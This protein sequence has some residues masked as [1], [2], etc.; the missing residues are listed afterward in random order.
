M[1]AHIEAD[2][3]RLETG[4]G[5]VRALATVFLLMD[6]DDDVAG[7]TPGERATLA[8]LQ[9]LHRVYNDTCCD[10]LES[11]GV[12]ELLDA[13]AVSNVAHPLLSGTVGGGWGGENCPSIGG[14]HSGSAS[15]S[16]S[17]STSPSASVTGGVRAGSSHSA[18]QLQ[19]DPTA[20]SPTLPLVR[21]VES[22]RL[23]HP[24]LND[25]VDDTHARV[26]RLYRELVQEFHSDDLR[27][28]LESL[29]LFEVVPPHCAFGM[30]GG[31]QL[32]PTSS[33][34]A[35]SLTSS[36]TMANAP[37]MDT[38]SSS[39][40][41][42][43]DLFEDQAVAL[44]T[45]LE[46]LEK[47]IVDVSSALQSIDGEERS[48]ILFPWSR[49]LQTP[50]EMYLPIQ[51]ALMMHAVASF[52]RV[53]Q[54]SQLSFKILKILTG[55]EAHTEI[56]REAS[57][58]PA[59]DKSS[60]PSKHASG[61]VPPQAQQLFG[62]HSWILCLNENLKFLKRPTTCEA[63]PRL[64]T[65]LGTLLSNLTTDGASAAA[66]QLPVLRWV[67]TQSGL[68][69][70]MRWVRDMWCSCSDHLVYLQRLLIAQ[71]ETFTFVIV[72]GEDGSHGPVRQV[73]T[74]P[75]TRVDRLVSQ[76]RSILAWGALCFRKS[77]VSWGDL[78]EAP[79]HR[80]AQQLKKLDLPNRNTLSVL[81]LIYSQ[82]ELGTQ[83]AETVD[84]DCFDG[85][86]LQS[87]TPMQAS[88]R[89]FLNE[90]MTAFEFEQRNV[91]FASLTV[92]RGN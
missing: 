22:W 37:R 69:Q 61:P 86:I 63:I 56:G 89:T 70:S 39:A 55:E 59:V 48:M 14:G 34:S 60:S 80:I 46:A 79:L 74:T 4:D 88:L 12:Y 8:G 28:R 44:L 25:S 81:H 77:F 72:E 87:A 1:L 7:T 57:A 76:R 58:M 62:A 3:R 35:S 68:M 13:L 75:T 9:L 92:R 82:L 32:A 52:Q 33:S 85:D 11:R 54:A 27:C 43:N 23:F 6:N 40:G 24:V 26:F 18:P 66:V 36:S 41:V 50:P 16:A 64:I 38:S 83:V 30:P 90:E 49:A 2:A 5:N 31:T 84:G 78:R 42:L 20:L 45:M 51:P 15:L 19:L 53:V 21:F 10:Y 91:K 73:T 29:Q 67:L 71:V 17:H 47:R 65:E